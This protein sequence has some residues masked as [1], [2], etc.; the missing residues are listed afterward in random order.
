MDRND[1]GELTG[2]SVRFLVNAL[3]LPRRGD[4]L[5]F[6]AGGAPLNLTVREIEQ[7][8]FTADEGPA[9][10]ELAVHAD[11][12]ESERLT[13][14]RLLNQEERQRWIERFGMLESLD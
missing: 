9:F 8:F 11:T 14:R 10:R 4:K 5:H 2:E 12:E 6:D 13:V 1:Q 3:A 7:W